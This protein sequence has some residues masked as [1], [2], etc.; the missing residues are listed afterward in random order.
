MESKVE[1][2]VAPGVF[3]R[4][5]SIGRCTRPLDKLCSA[6]RLLI[7]CLHLVSLHWRPFVEIGSEKGGRDRALLLLL[8]VVLGEENARWSIFSH[9]T[10]PAPT[11]PSFQHFR[12]LPAAPPPPRMGHCCDST[13]QFLYIYIYSI[14]NFHSLDF[15][16]SMA[17]LASNIS[18]IL[19]IGIE[20]ASCE[21]AGFS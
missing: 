9:A 18:K 14:S 13:S 1:D 4:R 8:L 16:N 10:S 19:C 3:P 5:S 12:R 11:P 2:R 21:L 6:H 15:L 20:L 7:D 17:S